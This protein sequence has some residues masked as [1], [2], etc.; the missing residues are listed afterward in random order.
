M[1]SKTAPDRENGSSK[2]FAFHQ[3][4]GED[5]L[6]DVRV[7]GQIALLSIESDAD[8]WTCFGD[9]RPVMFLI[10]QKDLQRGSFGNV[11]AMGRV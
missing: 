7:P 5:G 8:L 9:L 6:G 10:D 4:F 11:V 2:S 3:M 1:Q